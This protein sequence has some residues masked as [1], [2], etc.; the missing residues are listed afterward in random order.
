MWLTWYRTFFLWSIDSCQ[1][2]ITAAQCHMLRCTTNWVDVFLKFSADL[3]LVFNCSQFQG[4]FSEGI[5]FLLAYGES[6]IT[7]ERNLFKKF[8]ARASFFVLAKCIK[9]VRFD[10]E[11]NNHGAEIISPYTT[12]KETWSICWCVSGRTVIKV[13]WL[14]NPLDS[15][16]LYLLA[17]SD[18]TVHHVQ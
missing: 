5:Q 2:R 3:L 17:F 15:F 16:A 1:N 7:T 8:P 14:W 4:H 6:C 18:L 10:K 11:F 9:N 12:L 13:E